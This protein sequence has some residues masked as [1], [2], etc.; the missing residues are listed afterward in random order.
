MTRFAIPDMSCGHCRAAVEAAI[1]SV[2]RSARVAVDLPSRTVEVDSTASPA[3][4][5][6]ALEGAGYPATVAG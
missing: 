3:A 6:A 4:L 2:D 5:V 1:A